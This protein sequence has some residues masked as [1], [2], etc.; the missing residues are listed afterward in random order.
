MTDLLTVVTCTVGD[1]AGRLEHLLAELRRFTRLP[2]RQVVCDDGTISE[3]SVRKQ[4]EIVSRWAGAQWVQNNGPVWGIAHNLNHAMLFVDTP[5]VFLVEDGLRP[6]RGWLEAALSAIERIGSRT[7]CGRKVGMI[8]TSSMQDWQLALGGAIQ[9]ATMCPRDFF[10]HQ[11]DKVIDEFYGPWN[12]GLWCY[13]RLLPSLLAACRGMPPSYPEEMRRFAEIALSGVASLEGLHPHEVEQYA[14]KFC[15]DHRWPHKRTACCGWYPGAFMLVNMDAWR[16]VGR[17][18]EGCTFFE[19]H[20][21][22]RMGMAGYL[23]L[24]LEFPPWLHCPSQGF[25][26][27]GQARTPRDHRDTE[28]VF[29]ADWGLSYMDAPN[30]LA[31]GVVTL[32]EQRAINDKLAAVEIEAVDDWKVWL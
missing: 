2:F 10:M 7:W 31:T 28:A 5:W 32:D 30:V 25:R 29:Q 18:R 21:G 1:S 11:N 23:S 4:R 15:T 13:Q 20:L 24:V 27:S 19:G 6:S 16:A 12:D 8:G 26:M 17:F 14:Q 22:T 9:P 3:E